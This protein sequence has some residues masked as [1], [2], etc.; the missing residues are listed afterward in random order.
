MSQSNQ[1]GAAVSPKAQT[2]TQPAAAGTASQQEVSFFTNAEPNTWRASKLIGMDV[3]GANNQDIGEIN[4]VLADRNGQIRGL[5]LDVGRF[6]GALCSRRGRGAIPR[7]AIDKGQF[8]VMLADRHR[9]SPILRPERSRG[10]PRRSCRP[11][12]GA[13]ENR[14]RRY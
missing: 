14:A 5:I 13:G 12:H 6:L 9:G 8:A 10:Y 2:T 3:Y 11:R 4:D 1:P 7:R